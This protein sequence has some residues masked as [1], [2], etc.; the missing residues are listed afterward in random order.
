MKILKLTAENIKRLSAVEITPDGAIVKISGKNASGKTSVLDSIWWAMGGG[1]NIQDQPVHK[2]ASKGVITLDLGDLKVERRFTDKSTQ[3]F[4]TNKEG[5]RFPSPQGVL[6]E[7][8]GTLSFDPLEFMRLKPKEQFERLRHIVNIG[9][10][11]DVLDGKRAEL[12]DSRTVTNR[13]IKE[14]K[15]ALQQYVVAPGA[16][17][18]VVPASE[19]LDKIQ[20]AE[21]F[22]RDNGAMRHQLAGEIETREKL[23]GYIDEITQKL[24]DATK[25]LARSDKYIA[26]I[27]LSVDKL[28]DVD[29]DAMRTELDGI[30]DKN[31]Q[32]R[33]K[34]ARDAIA[35][36]LTTHEAIES[37][38]T[39]GIAAIDKQKAALMAKTKFPTDGLSFVDGEVMYKDLPLV[40]ASSAEQLRVSM[41]IAMAAN[42]KFRVIRIT[43]GSLMDSESFK[44]I[45]KM[46]DDNDYQIWVEVVDES[47]LVGVV[48]EDGRV[49]KVN[50]S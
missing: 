5:A 39:T 38:Q 27:Q 15:G 49:A 33:Q 10:E 44:L 6:D 48:I 12:Y 14:K 2:G 17:D 4:V 50:K 11:L 7:L 13:I 42:P 21:A 1:E 43:D 35:A 8:I 28:K 26:E 25:Q 9:D 36:D 34:Q 23:T 47:G 29:V 31:E 24:E 3:L 20:R 45:E 16:P 19:L 37:K 22:N 46:A 18:E 30:E 40:Q 32:A 41:S